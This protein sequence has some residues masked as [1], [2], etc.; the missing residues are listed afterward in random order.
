MKYGNEGLTS[1][2]EFMT[3]TQETGYVCSVDR[4]HYP[5]WLSEDIRLNFGKGNDVPMVRLTLRDAIEYA[6]W[7]SAILL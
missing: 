1:V 2:K 5:G 3:F 6:K 4:D 7:R